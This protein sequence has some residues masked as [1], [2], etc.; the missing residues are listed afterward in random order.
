MSL[1]NTKI[2]VGTDGSSRIEGQEKSDI[3]FKLSE[4]AK[5]AGKVVSDDSKDHQPVYQTVHNTKGA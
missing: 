5:A 4:L 1:P 2:I 3:C